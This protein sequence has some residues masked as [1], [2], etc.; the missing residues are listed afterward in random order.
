MITKEIGIEQE[1]I[2]SMVKMHQSDPNYF[3]CCRKNVQRYSK[4]FPLD[5]LFN[6]DYTKVII[7]ETDGKKINE[8]INE[9]D[10]NYSKSF[11][12]PFDN[13]F[14][15]HW[16]AIPESNKVTLTHGSF[17]VKRLDENVDGKLNLKTFYIIT[18]W[19]EYH[20]NGGYNFYVTIMSVPTDDFFTFMIPG[21]EEQKDSDSILSE[22]ILDDPEL[23]ETMKRLITSNKKKAVKT[24]IIQKIQR[25]LLGVLNQIK[26]KKY[27]TYK[28]W[29][30][31]GIDTKEIIYATE[32]STHKRHFYRETERFI[33]PRLKREEW[34][35]KGYGT[36]EVVVMEDQ[37]I[38]LNVPFRIIGNHL[39]KKGIDLKTDNR[40]IEIF[41]KRTFRCE[42]KIYSILREIYPDKIIRRHDRKTLNG[43]ELDFNIPELRLGI[44]YDGEQHFDKELYEKLYGDGFDEQ[45]KRDRLKDKLCRRKNIRLVRI[46]FDE[47]LTIR[48]IRNKLKW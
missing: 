16:A 28:K 8:L 29:T 43:I 14:I 22:N 48:H 2:A 45:V 20:Y 37:T 12:F 5:G 24:Q 17:I 35:A 41:K 33:I 27:T 25:I 26:N 40:I 21:I 23:N 36:D 31:S 38:R 11:I 30:P 34:E 4:K 7:F 3:T 6:I 44:E 19:E 9:K 32:V 42:E 46:K 1:E 47:P 39:S 13:I 18:P 15:K 10:A